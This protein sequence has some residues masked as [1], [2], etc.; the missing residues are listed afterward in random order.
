MRKE[1]M[2]VTL[3]EDPVDEHSTSTNPLFFLS[4]LNSK[5]LGI[6]ILTSW[7]IPLE[8]HCSTER[9]SEPSTY[10]LFMARSRIPFVVSILFDPCGHF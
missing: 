2:A 10:F 1:V 8:L 9:K 4:P 7:M 5:R 3:G 6:D